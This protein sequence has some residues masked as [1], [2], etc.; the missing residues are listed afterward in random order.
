[1]C[2]ISEPT[3]LKYKNEIKIQMQAEQMHNRF[4]SMPYEQIYQNLKNEQ[5]NQ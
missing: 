1:M 2:G 4:P 5:R 3:L